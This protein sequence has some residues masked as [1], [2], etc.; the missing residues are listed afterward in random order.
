VA[1]NGS[2]M[3]E[4]QLDSV[5]IF[6]SDSATTRRR[7]VVPPGIVGMQSRDAN[8]GDYCYANDYQH[9]K[10]HCQSTARGGCDVA[11]DIAVARCR[12]PGGPNLMTHG[13][14]DHHI[15][16]LAAC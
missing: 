13:L 14:G 12:A 6:N 16:V 3:L 11:F 9:H 10:H 5:L 15:L 4:H 1:E 7:R 2:A 8:T